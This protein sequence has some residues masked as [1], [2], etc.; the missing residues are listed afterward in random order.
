VE[1]IGI[2]QLRN[3]TSAAV[4][5]AMAGERI[6]ITIGGMPA[7]QLGPLNDGL[8]TAGIQDLIRAGLLHPP[9]SS[10]P[11]SPARPRHV[12]GGRPTI[13]ILREQR[14]R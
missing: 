12:R 7:A 10:S 2:R 6:V 5:R 14:D 11:P 13:E 3:E 8:R 9:R 4:R 1:S